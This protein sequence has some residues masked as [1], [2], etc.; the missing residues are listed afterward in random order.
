MRQEQRNAGHNP[1]AKDDGCDQA[2]TEQT[3]GLR[4]VNPAQYPKV[5]LIRWLVSWLQVRAE[6]VQRVDISTG[7]VTIRGAKPAFR[8]EG[9]DSHLE[10]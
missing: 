4:R 2:D 8:N 5:G 3:N 7:T 6:R 10:R 9:S 1:S